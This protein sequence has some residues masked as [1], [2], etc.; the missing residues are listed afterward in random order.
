M[1]FTYTDQ[2]YLNLPSDDSVS[3]GNELRQNYEVIAQALC[4][5]NVYWVSPDFTTAN[6]HNGSAT[7]R[8][9]FDTVQA[10]ITAAEGSTYSHPAT[11]CIWPGDY[12]EKLSITGSINLVGMVP[13][14]REGLGGLLGVQINGDGTENPV[15]TVTPASGETCCIGFSNINF[16]NDSATNHTVPYTQIAKAYL[17][18]LNDN[19]SSTYGSII[20]TCTFNNCRVRGQTWGDHNEWAYGI[21]SDGWWKLNL[22]DGFSMSGMKYAGNE[23]DGGI[24]ALISMVN[25]HGTYDSLLYMRHASLSQEYAGHSG[26]TA[27][28]VEIDDGV[29][30][31]AMRSDF[32]GS[33]TLVVDGG[34]GTNYVTGLTNNFDSNMNSYAD[35]VFY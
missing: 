16:N 5:E 31:N 20:N 34:T 6:L 28:F 8:R 32:A 17:I 24:E 13:A 21:R 14:V 35:G 33:A 11:I 1:S 4:P 22:V 9:H 15:I 26:G 12:S 30:G 19:A 2:L 7:D 27:K 10:A 29:S 3:H 23:N 18:Q 25:A